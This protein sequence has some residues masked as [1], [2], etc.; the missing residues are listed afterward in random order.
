SQV[1]HRRV[2]PVAPSPLG[3]AAERRARGAWT[4]RRGDGV[5]IAPS[6]G[7]G[8]LM[9][10]RPHAAELA[11]AVREFIEPVV[12]PGIDG[13]RLRCRTMVAAY[14]LGILEREVAIGE[15]LLRRGFGSIARI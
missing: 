2:D 1:G 7:S 11:Q 6:S 8:W 12:L 15:P 5:R 9:Q 4:A 3:T 14:G 10:D 13:P